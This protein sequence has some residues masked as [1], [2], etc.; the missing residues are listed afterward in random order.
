MMTSIT[1]LRTI[2]TS[3]WWQHYACFY[4]CY[5][6]YVK[7]PPNDSWSRKLYNIFFL[8]NPTWVSSA[9]SRK[10]QTI[11]S[12]NSANIIYTTQSI[13]LTGIS[14]TAVDTVLQMKIITHIHTR[15]HA[16]MQASTHA[17]THAQAHPPADLIPDESRPGSHV[18]G[19]RVVFP[20][21]EVTFNELGSHR[22]AGVVTKG[23]HLDLTRWIVTFP[24]FYI[25]WAIKKIILG[26]HGYRITR[27]ELQG[28]V[29][30][31]VIFY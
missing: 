4:H 26:L 16:R 24:N 14:H 5:V 25:L 30:Y 11:L 12:W 22:C 31:I 28:F 18:Y 19:V 20:V 23:H 10:L 8:W 1:K 9:R 2:V 13:I 3:N 27:M 15:K 17:R 29:V 21:A 6:N 7:R